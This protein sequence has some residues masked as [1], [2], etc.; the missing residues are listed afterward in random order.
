MRKLLLAV[1]S[2]CGRLGF[3]TQTVSHPEPPGSAGTV[4]GP[5]PA[6]IFTEDVSVP[7]ALRALLTCAIPVLVLAGSFLASHRG[8][9]VV[10][11]SA[12]PGTSSGIETVKPLTTED[13]ER[14]HRVAL[15]EETALDL[16][17]G[18]MTV[19]EAAAQFLEVSSSDPESLENM[20]LAP[21]DSDQEKA[22]SQLILYARVQAGRKPQRYAD[23]LARVEQS[24]KS[25]EKPRIVH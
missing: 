17:D 25:L 6:A 2:V 23:A 22:L 15:K 12:H 24:A 8:Q 1:R 21:G 19:E 3:N 13:E 20:R 16:L 5:N 4:V 10:A 11:R 7:S 18:R 9:E 14:M